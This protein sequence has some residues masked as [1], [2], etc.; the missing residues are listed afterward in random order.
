MDRPNYP[1]PLPKCA[2]FS[3]LFILYLLL[4]FLQNKTPLALI[5]WR[6]RAG[7]GVYA[8]AETATG[9][10]TGTGTAKYPLRACGCTASLYDG[11]VTC[12]LRRIVY[13]D[14]VDRMARKAHGEKNEE[15]LK[16][17]CMVSLG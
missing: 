9:T 4:H 8:F 17:R 15:N 5:A 6:W 1:I 7:R 16:M 2:P 12:T 3:L 10:G 14:N 13:L 11:G